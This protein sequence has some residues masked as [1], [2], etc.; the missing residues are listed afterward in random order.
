MRQDI[1]CLKSEVE[2]LKSA[3][4]HHQ[5]YIEFLE[6]TKRAENF[7]VYGMNEEG[8]SVGRAVLLDDNKNLGQFY[9]RCP[10]QTWL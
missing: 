4:L 1:E 5:S 6:S 2:C 8:L 7:I 10:S 9:R 3:L